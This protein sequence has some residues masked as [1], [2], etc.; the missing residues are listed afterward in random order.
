MIGPDSIRLDRLC[1]LNVVEQ[2]NNVC[3]TS[4]V[5]TAWEQDQPLAVHGWIYGIQDGLINDMDVTITSQDEIAPAYR[6][7]TKP[8]ASST[9]RD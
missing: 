7:A 9:S 4:V 5:Q 6:M 1:E 3:H 2:V 8:S